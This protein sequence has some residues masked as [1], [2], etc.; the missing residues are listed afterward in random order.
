MLLMDLAVPRDIDPG[1]GALADA[2]LYTI[3]DLERAVEENRASRREAAE[4]A[5]SIVELHVSRFVEQREAGTRVA[6]VKRLRAHGEQ[7]RD[8]VLARARQ[9][10]AS[11]HD[12]ARVLE[13]LANTLTNRLLHAPTVA[14]RQAALEGDHAL[15]K[16]SEKLFPSQPATDDDAAET[17]PPD[18]A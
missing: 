9:Q 17:T 16:A 3:D 5:E 6:P 4:A 13:F 11:G 10:L 7:A 14:L 1:V 12:P 8:E 2:F 15:A 18:A